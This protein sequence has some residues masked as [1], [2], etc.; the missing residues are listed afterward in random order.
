MAFRLEELQEHLPQFIQA[1]GFG[2]AHWYYLHLNDLGQGPFFFFVKK[3]NQKE[4]FSRE[5]SF[6]FGNSDL[7]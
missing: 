2:I 7:T 1:V 5:T 3:K 6:R 4:T